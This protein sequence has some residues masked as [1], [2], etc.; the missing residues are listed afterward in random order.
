MISMVY[1]DIDEMV[2]GG[3]WIFKIRGLP[4]ALPIENRVFWRVLE[5]CKE[6]SG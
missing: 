2:G 4:N 5:D 1:R 6:W 3:F